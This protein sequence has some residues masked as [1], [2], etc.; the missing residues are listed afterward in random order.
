MGQERAG[1][2]GP[3]PEL[4]PKLVCAARAPPTPHARLSP[5][6]STRAPSWPDVSPGGRRLPGQGVGAP[7]IDELGG[8]PCLL[9]YVRAVV[10]TE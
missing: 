10:G 7:S 5:Q 4:R 2:E 9:V 8:L 1:C 6:A 3:F